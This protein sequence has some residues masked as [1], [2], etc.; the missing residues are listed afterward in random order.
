VK[1]RQTGK[2]GSLYILPDPRI[3]VPAAEYEQQ[4]KTLIGIEEGVSEIHQGRQS[5]A[6]SQ[7]QINDLVELIDDKPNFKAV[8]DSGSCI[9][10]KDQ[11]VGR[12]K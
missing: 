3:N 7:Q 9:G 1:T 6:Q 10:Q 2:N 12:E 11:A 4:Q 8:A 5:N